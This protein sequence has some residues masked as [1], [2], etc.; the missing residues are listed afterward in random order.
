[1]EKHTIKLN[2][3]NFAI[4]KGIYE[5][6]EIIDNNTVIVRFWTSSLEQKILE[7]KIIL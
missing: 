5:L 7:V 6:V 1:M 4:K 3:Y 2:D